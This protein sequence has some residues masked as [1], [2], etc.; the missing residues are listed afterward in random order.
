MAL[1]LATCL[2]WSGAYG[3]DQAPVV[4]AIRKQQEINFHFQ[5]FSTF[6]SCS[7]LEGKI[8][9]ILAE[10]GAQAKVRVRDFGCPSSI[11]RMPRVI[12][13]VSSAIEATPE[14][15]AEHEKGRSTRE[16]AARVRGE[17]PEESGEMAQFPAAWQEITVGGV[18]SGLEAGDCELLRELRRKVLPKLAIR[19]IED[20]TTHCASG[21]LAMRRPR[22][23]VESLVAL[24]PPD[25]Q[26]A[27]KEP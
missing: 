14:A 11:A 25:E 22:L 20:D 18:R 15:L 1:A 16:L 4:Q 19:V 12:I 6:Y 5:S 7:A 9:S 13:Q 23:Q 3:A 17:R 2:A 27:L 24:P 21:Q 26:E 8:E 10:L